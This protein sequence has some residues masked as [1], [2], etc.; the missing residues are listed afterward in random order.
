MLGVLSV[1][2]IILAILLVC[3]VLIQD[4][5]GGAMGMF[6]GGSSSTVFGASGGTNFLVK[7]TT[8]IAV[9]FSITCIVL[10]NHT[11]KD[12]TESATDDFVPTKKSAPAVPGTPADTK[13]SP[14]DK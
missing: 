13:T 12:I 11:T 3:A 6:G 9:G 14:S 7:V 4:S 1:I 8:F 10:A 5:K 2:H